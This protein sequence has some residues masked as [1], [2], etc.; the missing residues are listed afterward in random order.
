MKIMVFQDFEV[1]NSSRYGCNCTSG[2]FNNAY[3]RCFQDIKNIPEKI[4]LVRPINIDAFHP[5]KTADHQYEFG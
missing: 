3:L 4:F 5:W 2:A 1:L